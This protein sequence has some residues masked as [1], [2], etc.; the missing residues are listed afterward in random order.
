[1][2][3][4]VPV[5]GSKA[6][7]H[8]I[9]EL[10]AYI[11]KLREPPQIRLLYVMNPIRP[12]PTIHGVSMDAEMAEKYYE[13][14]AALSTESAKALLEQA[15]TAFSHQRA[16]G[17]VAEEICR[18]AAGEHYDMIWMGTRG[19][20]GFA[21]LFLGS[22]ATKVLHGANIP[23]VLVPMHAPKPERLAPNDFRT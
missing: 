11:P 23:V 2:K 18:I 13:R 1:M 12:A 7:D 17:E 21:N 5:D 19:M 15:K 4:L 3:I 9:A 6:S 22:V 8:A 20:G 16:L 10:I 14:D